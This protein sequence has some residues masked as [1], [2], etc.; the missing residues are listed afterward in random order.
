MTII[1][2]ANELFRN[3]KIGFLDIARLVSSAL[4]NCKRVDT[5]SL[6]DILETDIWAREFVRKSI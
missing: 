6:E 2:K 5:Y 4:D 1:E 3:G